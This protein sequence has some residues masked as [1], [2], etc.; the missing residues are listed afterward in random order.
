MGWQLF[1]IGRFKGLYHETGCIVGG[2]KE[3][4]FKKIKNTDPLMDAKI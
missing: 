4:D 2:Y 3:F 1:I